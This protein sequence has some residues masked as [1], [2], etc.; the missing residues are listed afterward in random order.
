[1]SSLH[2]RP[3]LAA[4]ITAA[5]LAL[6]AAAQAATP[7]LAL[8]FDEGTGTTTA[9]ASGQGN[10]GT[11][12]G[13]AWTTAGK[14]GNALDFDGVDDLVEVAHASSLTLTTSGTLSAWVNPDDT[15]IDD[16]VFAKGDGYGLFASD[17]NSLAPSGF[18][19]RNWLI[20]ETGLVTGDWTHV[21]VTFAS[22]AP[23]AIYIDG[24]AV[25][26][27]SAQASGDPISADGPL[28]VGAA[29][30]F[31]NWFDGR[32]DDVR[33]YDVAL[34]ATEIAADRDAGV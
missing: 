26:A 19:G 17:Y 34:T 12:D 11:L 22:G 16:P 13:A 15:R 23:S 21:A 30:A 20:S 28:T 10:H 29:T 7:V 4:A 27:W 24:V 3:A 2:R 32:I 5:C 18:I 33:V 1:M 14:H 31:G 8:G 9:D 25:S 6:P